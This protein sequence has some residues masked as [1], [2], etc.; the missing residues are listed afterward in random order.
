MG[1][2]SSTLRSFPYFLFT[3]TSSDLSLQGALEFDTNVKEARPEHNSSFHF[4]GIKMPLHLGFRLFIT[5][6]DIFPESL[7]SVYVE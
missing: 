4:S 2:V 1:V 6:K 7:P 5:R 3:V